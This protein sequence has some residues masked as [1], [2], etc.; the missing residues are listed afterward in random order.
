MQPAA[1]GRSGAT[2]VIKGKG[3]RVAQADGYV[4]DEKFWN[5][6]VEDVP[7]DQVSRFHALLP[8]L[9]ADCKV[10]SH[11]QLF[12]H[13]FFSIKH[14][15]Q[16]QME[17]AKTK[18]NK[19]GESEFGGSVKGEP[20]GDESEESDA[21]E[22]EVWKV[23]VLYAL[24]SEKYET[25]SLRRVHRLCKHPCRRLRMTCTSWR[26]V[27]TMMSSTAMM[28]TRTRTSR[29]GMRTTSRWT[30]PTPRRKQMVQK[31][32]DLTQGHRARYAID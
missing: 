23:R 16:R 32:S 1:V 28:T 8:D 14:D 20:T 22:A 4:N 30:Q 24:F 10:F 19:K 27:M 21:E 11:N 17:S 2:S 7:A 3:S 6:K 12:F 31:V 29:R 5:K 9:S 25:D 26:T 13:K 15:R 18:R